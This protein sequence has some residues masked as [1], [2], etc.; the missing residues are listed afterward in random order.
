MLACALLLAVSGWTPDE[1]G[2][3]FS[4]DGTSLTGLVGFVAAE[5]GH[6][7]AIRHRTWQLK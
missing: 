7:I 1:E 2:S 5:T 4:L 3:S 6:P